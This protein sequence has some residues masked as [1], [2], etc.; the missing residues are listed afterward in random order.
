MITVN[1]KK[2]SE[3]IVGIE[4]LVREPIKASIWPNP[5]K[6]N[7]NIKIETIEPNHSLDLKIYNLLGQTI[8][9]E[10]LKGETNSLNKTVDLSDFPTGTYFL[11]L[12][13]K[14]D[15]YFTKII[16]AK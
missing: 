3:T 4:S 15:S 12:E 7:F 14:N 1:V 13:S 8:Y 16:I 11:Q 5:N 9:K 10:M 6:G 2:L